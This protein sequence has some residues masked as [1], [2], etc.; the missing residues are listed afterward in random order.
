MYAPQERNCIQH[1]CYVGQGFLVMEGRI[2]VTEEVFLVMEG[3][4]LVTEERIPVTEEVFLVMEGRILV[5]EEVFLV[6]EE[7]FLVVEERFVFFVYRLVTDAKPDRGMMYPFENT[8]ACSWDFQTDT[9]SMSR[10]RHF[11]S[12]TRGFSGFCLSPTDT[13]AKQDGH[14]A[15]RDYTERNGSSIAI[16][17]SVAKNL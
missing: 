6:M 15:T 7:G 1:H 16:Y 9:A 10:K 13:G 8:R 5:T 4:V 2:L 3:R 17:A 12:S 14:E 11:A